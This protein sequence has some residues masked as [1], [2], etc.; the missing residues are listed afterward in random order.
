[1]LKAVVFI[2]VL[3]LPAMAAAEPDAQYVAGGS[4]AFLDADSWSLER[5]LAR[6]AQG[7]HAMQGVSQQSGGVKNPKLAMLYS[8]LLPGMGEYYLGHKTRA[9]AFWMVEGGIWTTH[10]VFRAQGNSGKDRY[11]E[12]AELFAGVSRRDN[13]DYYR[14]IGNYASSE[15]PRSANEFVRRRARALYP[16]DPDKRRQYEQENGYYGDDSWDWQDEASLTRYQHMRDVSE[17]AYDNAS[18]TLGLLVANRLLSVLDAGILA[19][20]YEK[21]M[22]DGSKAQLQWNVNWGPEG[23]NAGVVV[24]RRF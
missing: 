10:F 4:H 20:K 7:T 12:W 3:A 2:F 1:M 8:L 15:G 19:R 22:S 23:P 14:T 21:A 17:N 11:K 5:D 13:D 18:L 16:T 24:S 9:A 6:H